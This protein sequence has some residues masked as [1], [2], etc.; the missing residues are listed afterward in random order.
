MIVQPDTVVG[1]H[2]QGFRL[3]W[4]WKSRAKVGRPKI[5]AEIRNL[6]RRMSRKNP[7]WGVPRIQS[8]LALLGHSV[9]EATVRKYRIRKRKPPSQTW[10]TFLAN[11]LTDIVAIDFFTVPT[12]TFRI[13]FAFVA[14]R[15]DRRMVVH[16]NA[17]ANPT[18]AWTAQQITEA[19]PDETAP[20]FLIRDRD[21]IYGQV[22]QQ[23]IRNMGIEEVVTTPRSPWQNPYVERLL[24]SI[25]RECLNHVIVLNER[26]LLRILRS[27][28][29]YYHESRTHLSLDRNSPI[30]REVDP[31]ECGK[32]IAIPQV[33]GLHHRYCR[34]A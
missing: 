4:R 2:R 12:A 22:F 8:E 5:E 26:H 21:G 29:A 27:Y 6:I 17:T 11:H 34:A 31:P 32:L 19:F 15:Q 20:R 33:G 9:S 24:G 14:L 18:A 3:Y 16:F 23:R 28:F 7:S 10:Q 13:L 30:Q 25:R 1:W